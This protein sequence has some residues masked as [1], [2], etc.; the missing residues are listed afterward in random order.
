[1]DGSKGGLIWNN[2]DLQ[3][4]DAEKLVWNGQVTACKSKLV[5]LLRWISVECV[6]CQF[7]LSIKEVLPLEY[8]VFVD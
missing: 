5:S 2:N 3:T 7:W 6:Q 4:I 8:Q 1:M